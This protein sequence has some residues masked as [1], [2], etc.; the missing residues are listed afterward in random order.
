ML[1]PQ[2]VR[3]RLLDLVN[4]LLSETILLSNKTFF[5]PEFFSEH[6]N[7]EPICFVF[8]CFLFFLS[9][10]KNSS[11]ENDAWLSAARV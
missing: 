9:C 2:L 8:W 1:L 10:L 3:A 11:T 4:S 7:F 5:F 6:V